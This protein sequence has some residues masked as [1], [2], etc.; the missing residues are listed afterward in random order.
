MVNLTGRAA[1]QG[2]RGKTQR[3]LLLQGQRDVGN[4]PRGFSGGDDHRKE[5]RDV[6]RLALNFSIGRGEFQGSSGD[7]NW[8]NGSGVRHRWPAGVGLAREML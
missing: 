5:A 7:G 1:R 8:Q 3:G 6:T 4:A 2:S